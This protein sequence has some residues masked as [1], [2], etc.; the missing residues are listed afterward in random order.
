MKISIAYTRLIVI[1][2]ATAIILCASFAWAQSGTT[3]LRGTVLDKS[4]AAVKADK[5]MLNSNER[6]FSRT[7]S[8]GST[9]EF[10]F[11]QLPPGTYSL[12]VE[13]AGFKTYEQSIELLVNTPS[14]IN[15]VLEVGNAKEVVEVRGES[16]TVNT[17]DAS[18]GNSFG[19]SEVKTL[20]FL[21]RNVVNLLMVQPGV[22]FTGE[23]DTDQLS[24]GSNNN[25]D[26]REGA[27]NGVRGN[28]TNVTLDGVDDNDWQNQSAFTS[29]L[30]VTLDSVQEFRVTTTNANTTEGVS[31]GAQVSLVTKSGTNAWHGD[32]RWYYRTS[33]ATANNYF[34]NL[35]DIPRPKLQRNIAGGSLG[36]PIK[37]GRA[38]FFLDNEERREAS[39]E[40]VTPRIVPTDSLRNGVL[41][42]S[43]QTASQCPGGTVQGN[44]VPAGSFGLTPAQVQQLDPAGLG[45]NSAMLNYMG[46]YPHGNDPS[47]G[48][49]LGLNFTGVAF[50]APIKVATNVYTARTDFM[51]TRDG[52]HSMFVRGILSGIGDD[53]VPAQFPGQSAASRLLNNSRGI[54]VQYQALI[55]PSAL[56]TLRYGFTRL[57]IEQSG[58]SGPA[59]TVLPFDDIF[60]YG[61]A[62]SHKVPVNQINDDFSLTRGTHTLQFGGNVL[63]VRNHRVSDAL[64]FPFYGENSGWC[65]QQCADAF[66]SLALD[67]FPVAG[68]EPLFTDAFIALT[69]AVTNAR[70]SYLADPHSGSFLAPGSPDGRT[71]AENDLELYAQ[72]NWRF[73]PNLSLT[74]G[75]RYGYDTP[76]WETNGYQV[77]PTIDPLAWFLQRERNMYAGIP[78]DASP[79][80]SWGL[81]G[82]ANG[83]GSWWQP[84]RTNFAPRVALAWSPGYSDGI[85]KTVF[86]G[87]GKSSIRAGAGIFFSRVGQPMA[88]DSDLNGSPGTA[89]TL[90]NSN[91]FTL[92]N[93]PRFSGSCNNTVCSD[94][95]SPDLYFTP[96]TSATF[97]LTPTPNGSNVGFAIDNRLRTPY[98]MNFTLS[99]QRQLP[100][101]FITD[102]AYVGSLGR[103]LLAKT[104]YAEYTGDMTDPTS[105]QALWAAYGQ[106]ATLANITPSHRAPAINPTDF[107]QLATIQSIPFFTNMLPNM[108][109]FTAAYL[110]NPAYA[111]LTPTQAFYSYVMQVSAPSWTDALFYM[112][113]PLQF[114]APSPWNMTVDPQQNGFVIFDPQFQSMPGW[115][116]FGSSNYHSL[117]LSIRK[118]A[119][120][121]SLSANYVF[122][123]SIDNDSAAENGDLNPGVQYQY[124]TLNGLILNPFDLRANRAISDFDIRHNFSASW[125]IALPFGKG[126]RYGSSAGSTRDALIGGWEISQVLRIRSGLPLSPGDDYWATNWFVRSN[127]TFLTPVHSGVT[128][129]GPNGQPNLFS[130]ANAAYQ[131][132]AFTMP[133]GSG[134]RNSLESPAFSSVD[135]A[136]HKSFR[137]PWNENDRIQARVSAYNLFNTVNFST[138]SIALS[139]SS[140][141]TFGQ[142]SNTAGPRGGAREMEFALRYEF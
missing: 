78:S 133:G 126:K 107:S 68:N 136:I 56:N 77:A 18:V 135:M 83:K 76:V 28:Q 139:P 13:V 110:N 44:S 106:I 1:I 94:F 118:T 27:V 123:K 74:L 125:V 48:P 60:N 88:V 101:G 37:K 132:L 16:A 22:V 116:N 102:I 63:F 73:R 12:R 105:K 100:K 98:S 117:Q 30:P 38:Y 121:F 46:L 90:S 20:P 113:R 129:H 2:A 86:G 54:A 112:D 34:N 85:L 36:G 124:K 89:T 82:K 45:V 79:L 111:N 10:E 65:L 4:G 131:Q 96:P 39:A 31:G 11:L 128:R 137:M 35:N 120:I 66:N 84:V 49:D 87:A 109:A 108:P 72:D 103:R 99:V 95:P 40:A 138:T 93:A 71:F 130:D 3:S 55:S 97:P 42:Y 141:G 67:G 104:D 33:G 140:Q 69:G 15:A 57:G 75:L 5:I 80:L 7:T 59:F 134:S 14:T 70:A 127:G 25:L 50:N 23:S 6:A 17:T 52:R 19:E 62:G 119:G 21:A 91:F 51:L 114:S 29:A 58:T 64:S 61:R 53:L 26:Q 122:S 142:I 92:A 43:C 41:I 9:G 47:I 8:S 32:V 24:L 115:T 81:A